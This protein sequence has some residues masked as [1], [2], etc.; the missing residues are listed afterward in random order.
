MSFGGVPLSDSSCSASIQDSSSAMISAHR[1]T[2]CVATEIEE[3]V[4]ELISPSA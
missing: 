2:H 3:A 4:L 1:L